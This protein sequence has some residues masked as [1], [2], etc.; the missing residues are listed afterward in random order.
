MSY[1]FDNFNNNTR[2]IVSYDFN[3]ELN[4]EFIDEL[5]Q[6]K[7]F[8]LVFNN[9]IATLMMKRHSNEF[10]YD[11]EKNIY[12][13]GSVFNKSVDLL[14]ET[15]LKFIEFGSKFNKSI[16]N[17]PETLETLILSSEF[18]QPLDNLPINLIYLS[19]Y[20]CLK[21]DYNLDYLPEGLKTLILPE[22]YYYKPIN[23]LPIGTKVLNLSQYQS[24]NKKLLFE[25]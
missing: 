15:K 21:F 24:N 13:R 14:S 8:N 19:L 11:V 10:S 7:S 1:E 9:L 4:M 5:N 25:Y 17:L 3:K 16:S 23:N 6:M 20:D 18:N 2:C 12:W 22:N